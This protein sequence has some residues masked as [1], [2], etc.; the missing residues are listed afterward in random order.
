MPSGHPIAEAKA[1]RGTTFAD[2]VLGDANNYENKLF[3]MLGS[4]Y[5]EIVEYLQSF[6]DDKNQKWL[7]GSSFSVVIQNIHQMYF[8]ICR[9]RNRSLF[10]LKY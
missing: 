7:R 6:L 8:Y 10:L 3:I 9:L 4:I 1:R 2:Q 5:H